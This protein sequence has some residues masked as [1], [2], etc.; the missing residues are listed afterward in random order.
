MEQKTKKRQRIEVEPT[1]GDDGG[2]GAAPNSAGPTASEPVAKNGDKEASVTIPHFNILVACTGSVASVKLPVLVEALYAQ[3][4]ASNA[5][6]S[7]KV[8]ATEPAL[9][10]FDPAH[11]ALASRAIPVLRDADEYAAWQKMGDE[12]LHIAL[13]NWADALVVAPLSANSLA[14]AANGMCDNLLTCVL[15]A[16]HLATKPVW[17]APAMNTAM[18]E[19]PAT[20]DHL[21]TLQRWG[22]RVIDPISK[23]LACGDIG[24][25]AMAEPATIAA[26]VL[27]GLLLD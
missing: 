27:H 22:Y 11:P 4:A 23:K 17:V 13:R 15:R 19:H 12:V 10:F 25:G 9:H 20:A 14:K 1:L 7:I 6:F 8:I 26:T 24:T 18:W 16:W 5:T 2:R 21:A 3:A